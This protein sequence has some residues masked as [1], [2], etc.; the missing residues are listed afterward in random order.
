MNR[1]SKVGVGI[2]HGEASQKKTREKKFEETL[3]SA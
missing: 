2:Q 1:F 3:G